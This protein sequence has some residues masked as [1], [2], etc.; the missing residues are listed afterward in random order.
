MSLN[1]NLLPKEPG[2]YIMKDGSGVVIYV[3]KAINIYNR[4]HQYFQTGAENSRGWKIPSLV[5][6]IA[7]IDF[8]VCAS[9]RD[10]LIL[11]NRLIKKYKN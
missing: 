10:A 9:E 8:V 5:P 2:V 7:K 3:G 6:L 4:V 1:L 11:E